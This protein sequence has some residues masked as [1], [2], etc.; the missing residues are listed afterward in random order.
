M[1]RAD[2][3]H[4]HH[5]VADLHARIELLTLSTSA[6]MTMSRR[7]SEIA[8]V[9]DSGGWRWRRRSSA[10][11]PVQGEVELEHVDARLPEHPEAATVRCWRRSAASTV[12]SEQVTDGGD[13]VGLDLGVGR[14]DVRVEPE[15]ELVAASTGTRAAVRAAVVWLSRLQIGR[16]V[17]AIA[18][19]VAVLFGPRLVNAVAAALWGPPATYGSPVLDGRLWKYAGIGDEQRALR[20]REQRL[21]VLHA[22]GSRT[23]GR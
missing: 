2:L 9:A 4:E 17:A 7:N 21:A 11:A 1:T 18:C 5:R 3:D 22:P 19:S 23:S 13:A 10:A 14:R 16:D 12:P 8:A 20:A 15:A 6:R